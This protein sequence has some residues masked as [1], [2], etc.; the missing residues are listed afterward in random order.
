MLHV[1]NVEYKRRRLEATEQGTGFISYRQASAGLRR[2]LIEIA[3]TGI[4]PAAIVARA[5]EDRRQ[6][7]Q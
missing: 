3:A 5:F 6:D 7:L 1:F 2:A 4:A